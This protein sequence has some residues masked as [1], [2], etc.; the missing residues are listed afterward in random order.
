MAQNQLITTQR[1][2]RHAVGN[3]AAIAVL[4]AE[5]VALANPMAQDVRW[6][7]SN[8]DVDHIV[9]RFIAMAHEDVFFLVSLADVLA[10]TQMQSPP[11]PV[12]LQHMLTRWREQVGY[13]GR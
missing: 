10:E 12:T 13:T 9:A 3:L 6:R 2:L 8:E 5:L 4:H 1:E 11:N 7:M